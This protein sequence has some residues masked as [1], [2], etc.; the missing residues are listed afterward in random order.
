MLEV[1]AIDVELGQLVELDIGTA[2]HLARHRPRQVLVLVPTDPDSGIA[3]ALARHLGRAERL[4]VVNE[5][6]MTP[7]GDEIVRQAPDSPLTSSFTLVTIRA[8]YPLAAL[9]RERRADRLA[10]ALPEDGHS[11][12]TRRTAARTDDA[13]AGQAV[14]WCG[15]IPLA[16]LRPPHLPLL[17]AS[18]RRGP[19]AQ[20]GLTV[21]FEN[22]A[23]VLRAAE[24]LLTRGS[25]EAFAAWCEVARLDTSATALPRVDPVHT[26]DCVG[27]DVRDLLVLRRATLGDREGFGGV[28]VDADTRSAGRLIV[29]CAGPGRRGPRRVPAL[30]LVPAASRLRRVDDRRARLRRRPAWRTTRG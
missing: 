30:Y 6:P 28:P 20:A 25:P 14:G 22:P 3:V 29:L 11:R 16:E 19:L 5:S 4:V 24:V 26:G 15:A 21:D 17:E 9:R 7:I 13:L 27:V 1:D 23:T 8:V 18:S 2:R 10:A 12:T